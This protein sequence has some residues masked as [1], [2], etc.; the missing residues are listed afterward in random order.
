MGKH[1]QAIVSIVS[2]AVLSPCLSTN[3][4]VSVVPVDGAQ[5]ILNG[6]P[7]VMLVREVK[8]NGFWADARAATAARMRVVEN[9]IL[10]VRSFLYG[11]AVF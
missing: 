8:V 5:V 9:C 3:E 10:S 7:A 4:T 6:V 11:E 2:K 1:S